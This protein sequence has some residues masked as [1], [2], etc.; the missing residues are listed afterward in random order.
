M[1]LKQ[2]EGMAKSAF[3]RAAAPPAQKTMSQ[4]SAG[5]TPKQPNNFTQLRP[6]MNGPKPPAAVS[7]A[8]NRQIH[9]K[10][11]QQLS[12][13]AKLKNDFTRAAAPK[14][15]TRSVTRTGR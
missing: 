9:A 5:V 2:N 4:K 12:Q 8:V 11:L 15:A 14:S 1:G 13:K 3:N 10:Q 6:G 7:Q